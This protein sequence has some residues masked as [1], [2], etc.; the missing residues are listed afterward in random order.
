M[1]DSDTDGYRPIADYCRIDLYIALDTIYNVLAG[2]PIT[3]QDMT[4]GKGAL[5]GL[6]GVVP[7]CWPYTTRIW[8]PASPV[9]ALPA[10]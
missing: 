9:F 2:C 3:T 4:A 1:A 6:E 10:A 8:E 7:V 5:N